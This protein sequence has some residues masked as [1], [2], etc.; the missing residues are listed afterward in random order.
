MRKYKTL[1]FKGTLESQ[2]HVFIVIKYDI[3]TESKCQMLSNNA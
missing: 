2:N 3:L 1:Y